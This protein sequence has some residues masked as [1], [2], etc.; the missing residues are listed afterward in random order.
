MEINI[1]DTHKERLV[2][3]GAGF[4]GLILARNIDTSRYQLVLIDRHNYHTFQPLLYQVATGGLEPGS[5][6]HPLRKFIKKHKEVILRMAEVIRIDADA[7]ELHTS[8]GNL[9]YDKLILATGSK[10]NF[11]GHEQLPKFAMRMKTVPQ[12]LDLRSVI[13]QHFEEALLTTGMEARDRLTTFVVVGGGPTGVETAGALAELKKHVLPNDYPE[14]DIR[15]MQIHL[16]EAGPRLLAGMSER[17]SERTLHFLKELGVQVWLNHPVADYNGQTVQLNNGKHIQSATVIWSAGVLG[18]S[19][20]GLSSDLF[21]RAG[22]IKVDAFNQVSG[23]SNLFA[24]GDLALMQTESAW[25][26]GHPMVAPVA[27]QQA[28]NLAANL[29]RLALGKPMKP[30]RYFDKGSMATI[31][32][33]RAVVDMGKLRFQGFFAWFVWMFVHLMSIVGFRNK[34]VVFVDWF[35]NYL[36]Y[37]RAL[38][39]IIR[40]F[41]RS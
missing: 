12:A 21:G 41:N 29:N 18:A 20:A 40:P 39:L 26:Q 6:A 25:P 1:P 3:V 8:I 35:W 32:R 22:R 34:M 13:L 33:N 24:V 23:Y 30:F 2:L 15:R 9:K 5:I 14:L 37:D 38:R 16:I 27:I 19:P 28:K 17:A 11:F 7:A 4:A 31:G 36:S 10:T